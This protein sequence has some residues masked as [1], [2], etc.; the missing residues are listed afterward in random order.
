M[1]EEREAEGRRVQA[2][3]QR[4]IA[5][6]MSRS[7]E[8]FEAIA[9]RLGVTRSAARK[10]VNREARDFSDQT[11][12]DD[13]RMV[14]VEALMELWRALYGAAT[15]G[16]LDAIDRFLRV[17]ERLSRLLALDMADRLSVGEPVDAEANGNGRGF[18]RT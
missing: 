11:L 4:R 14:H 6:Q 5:I 17:E 13:R 1:S 2:A 8:S 10:M 7:G 18:V 9:S 16:D 3:R 15:N 12:A